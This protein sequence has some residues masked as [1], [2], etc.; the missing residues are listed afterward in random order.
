MTPSQVKNQVKKRPKH[1]RL[2]LR[3]G[4][5]VEDEDAVE[6]EAVAGV[7]AVAAGVRPG[8]RPEKVI[9]QSQYPRTAIVMVVCCVV[10]MRPTPWARAFSRRNVAMIP[11]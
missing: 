11:S 10:D 2:Y 1:L 8:R 6:G 3:L 5:A 4:P 7:E 9:R